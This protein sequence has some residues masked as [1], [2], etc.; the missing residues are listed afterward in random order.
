MALER[1]SNLI[2][3]Q[4]ATNLG[5]SSTL[6]GSMSPSSSCA[7]F[8]KNEYRRYALI[9]KVLLTDDVMKSTVLIWKFKFALLYP[10]DGRENQ[11]LSFNEGEC[12][13]ISIRLPGGYE[14][15]K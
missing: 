8:D 13:E 12:V 7:I 4:V 15:F 14:N 10:Y 1:L 2:V 11:P 9:N 6:D 5:S 3:G